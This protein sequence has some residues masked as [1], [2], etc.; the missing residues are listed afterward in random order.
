MLGGNSFDHRLAINQ[1]KSLRDG[2]G[3]IPVA[4]ALDTA[5]RQVSSMQNASREIILVTDFQSHE[6]SSISSDAIEAIKQQLNASAIPIHLSFLTTAAPASPSNLSVSIAPIE[7]P[8]LVVNQP[9]RITA[10]IR[11]HTTQSSEDVPVVLQVAG[12]DIATRRVSIPANGVTQINF[13]CQMQ[14]EGT[15]GIAVRIEDESGL[16]ADNQAFQVVNVK[17]P[18]RVLLVDEQAKAA[19]L[20]RASGYLS[21]ALSPFSGDDS[22]KNTVLVRMVRPSDL[23]RGEVEQNAVVVLVDAPRLNDA[24]ANEVVDF[25]RKGGGLLLFSGNS[26][27]INWYNNRWGSKSNTPILPFDFENKPKASLQD[28]R[29]ATALDQHP[30]LRF[31]NDSSETEDLSTVELKRLQPL[32]KF[33]TEKQNAKANQQQ[34]DNVH[35]PYVLL[36]SNETAPVAGGKKVGDGN[37]IQFAMA[38]D[39]SDSNLPLRPAYLPLMQGIVHW[40][41]SG[42]EPLRNINCG[43]SFS[44]TDAAAKSKDAFGKGCPVEVNS[45]W[46]N[47]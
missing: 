27:D 40:L 41:A 36:T 45:T 28:A 30:V 12:T 11:N 26:S 15:H 35:L 34:V 2:A 3:S 20:K 21:L 13:D 17:N 24:T 14:S 25:V 18:I 1:L 29:I 33:D 46:W 23:L 39:D 37:V 47:L 16:L 43:Q 10:Q 32:A 19:E 8:I 22:D 38:A 4:T 44:I 31:L 9:I 42:S 6:W 7:D 5:I